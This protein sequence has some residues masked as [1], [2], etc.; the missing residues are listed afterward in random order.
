MN[1]YISC[2]IVF[3]LIIFLFVSC[4]ST[5]IDEDEFIEDIFENINMMFET[6][7]QDYDFIYQMKNMVSGV[8]AFT[9]SDNGELYFSNWI[10]EGVVNEIIDVFDLNGNIIDTINLSQFA[11][12]IA[13][14]EL[15]ISEDELENLTEPIT[16]S[17][18]SFL[19]SSM[20]IH[21]NFIYFTERNQ[22]GSTSTRVFYYNIENE[23]LKIITTLESFTN[24]R[25]IVFSGNFLYLHGRDVELLQ[26]TN[27]P[28]ILFGDSVKSVN[29]ITGDIETVFDESPIGIA[30]MDD[31]EL[32]VYA[33][34]EN[35]GFYFL[36]HGT[37][38]RI[39]NNL[40]N[41][42]NNFYFNMFG[43]SSI[44]YSFGD[45][46]ILTTL[47]ES[48]IEREL[49]RDL[50]FL[51]SKP[52]V[53]RS[54]FL[55]YNT[56]SGIR[57]ICV[58]EM[59]LGTVLNMAHTDPGGTAYYTPVPVLPAL[60]IQTRNMSIGYYDLAFRI[61]SGDNEID[62]YYLHSQHDISDNIRRRG[63][64]YTLNDIPGIW[65]Y[66]DAVF[67]YVRDAALD[68]NG[69]IWMLPIAL[70]TTLFLYNERLTAEFGIDIDS[71]NT[72]KDLTFVINDLR[73]RNIPV[74]SGAQYEWFFDRYFYQI[75]RNNNGFNRNDFRTMAEFFYDYINFVKGEWSFQN[76]QFLNANDFAYD[77]YFVEIDGRRLW[78]WRGRY[79]FTPQSLSLSRFNINLALS[80]E[81]YDDE[82]FF[83]QLKSMYDGTGVYNHIP[84]NYIHNRYM[85]FPSISGMAE[86]DIT[87]EFIAVN[88]N[89]NNLDEVIEFLTRLIEYQ[90]NLENSFILKDRSTYTD[91]HY[92]NDVYGILN[93]KDNFI[94]FSISSDLIY[95]D[96]RAFL[97]DEITLDEYL[98]RVEFKINAYL[99]E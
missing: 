72:F 35:E 95:D 96:F 69:D 73:E 75:M 27:R 14:D 42:I 60:G 92:I 58:R 88:P 37:D 41:S 71:I 78:D 68:E 18:D 52:F 83:E 62:I 13:L 26:N 30:G 24:V 20:T 89:S 93:Y 98:N 49:A 43:D 25:N 3:F 87:V 82:M 12:D 44:I 45:F 1:K 77:E 59:T 66:L 64:F 94:R 47:D 91:R 85:K 70:D 50:Y 22:F 86:S 21:D 63:A 17:L 57:R 84:L 8:Y 80:H 39:Y 16:I 34:D 6:D 54:G 29:L 2:L 19:P 38:V 97:G 10:D 81:I 5:I 4:K 65:E 31:D 51:S 76:S 15:G 9:V 48:D 7:I 36:K 74:D 79:L 40:R 67:P 99:N 90:M 33:Y 61:L 55:F 28:H 23:E 46:L 56:H 11:W 53:A 32:M